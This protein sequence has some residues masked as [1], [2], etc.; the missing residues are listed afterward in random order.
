M[1]I[2]DGLGVSKYKVE[3][4]TPLESSIALSFK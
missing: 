4:G 1:D 3:K 2:N